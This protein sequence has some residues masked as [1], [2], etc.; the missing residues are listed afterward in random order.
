[1]LAN[2]TIVLTTFLPVALSIPRPPPYL[3]SLYQAMT[4]NL[5]FRAESIL[6]SQVSRDKLSSTPLSRASGTGR[7]SAF[8]CYSFFGIY[9]WCFLP[10]KDETERDQRRRSDRSPWEQC[11]FLMLR[12]LKL[13]VAQLVLIDYRL[14]TEAFDH[15]A[16][17]GWTQR[18]A[19]PR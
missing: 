15:P 7:K 10:R 6:C 8:H 4:F 11:R 5:L 1:M 2:S 17:Q 16:V 18:E 19:S 12:S 3:S 14:Q 9:S 13:C